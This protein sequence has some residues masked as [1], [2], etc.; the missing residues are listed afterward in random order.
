MNTQTHTLFWLVSDFILF[1]SLVCAD[2]S[3]FF[4]FSVFPKLIIRLVA[5]PIIHKHT[6]KHTQ[7][8]LVKQEKKAPK[9]RRTPHF[10]LRIV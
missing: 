2:A 7:S 5:G 3:F 9:H 4:S 6:H 8:E 10:S 1:L